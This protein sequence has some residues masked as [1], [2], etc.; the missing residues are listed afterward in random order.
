MRFVAISPAPRPR[1]ALLRTNLVKM[2][3]RHERHMLMTTLVDRPNSALIVIYLQNGVVANAFRREMVLEAVKSLVARGR[4]ARV[5]VM[6]VRQCDED[7]ATG[8]EAW[9]IVS[10]LSPVPAE[11][12]IEKHYRDAFEGTHLEQVLSK[13]GVGNL[14]VTGAQ[15]DMCIRS[16]LHGALVRG[17][18]AILV[19]D[20][21]TTDDIRDGAQTPLSRTRIS[22]GAI[23]A[24][25]VGWAASSRA[26][27]SI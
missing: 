3:D 6:W 10:E 7:L 18:D 1:G 14:I 4:T 12:V 20:A 9:Q 22:T 16:T 5:P 8:S 23:K 11:V 19:T 15:T 13:L 24:R 25:P 17:Y 21:H 2:G 26:K 27:R